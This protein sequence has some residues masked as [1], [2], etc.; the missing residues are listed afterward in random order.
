[1]R[2]RQGSGGD[3]ASIVITQ[4][5]LSLCIVAKRRRHVTTFATNCRSFATNNGPTTVFPNIILKMAESTDDNLPKYRR[6]GLLALLPTELSHYP[7]DPDTLNQ[8]TAA[9]R[10]RKKPNR[11]TFAP[12]VMSIPMDDADH[13]D[14]IEFTLFFFSSSQI[15]HCIRFRPIL[16]DF[17]RRNRSKCRCIYIGNEEDNTIFLAGTGFFELPL[18]APQRSG[19]VALLSASCVPSIIVVENGSGRKVTDAGL[20]A[21]EY[22]HTDQTSNLFQ[23]WR[24]RSSGL[25]YTQWFMNTSCTVC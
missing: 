20:P 1:M 7:H 22:C 19:I 21:I 4:L 5:L 8:A 12:L 9:L 25:T 13:N 14:P 15:G 18:G 24:Q 23:A 10:K 6:R 3:E 16:V 11:S 2:N 17:V